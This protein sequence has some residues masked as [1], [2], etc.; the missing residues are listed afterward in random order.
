L[1]ILLFWRLI[2]LLIRRTIRLCLI[3]TILLRLKGLI[4]IILYIWIL[5]WGIYLNLLGLWIRILI[6]LGYSILL[7]LSIGILINLL[8]RLLVYRTRLW[9][10]NWVFIRRLYLIRLTLRYNVLL[11]SRKRILLECYRIRFKLKKRIVVMIL[12]WISNRSRLAF[13]LR[14]WL[15]ILILKRLFCQF[16]ILLLLLLW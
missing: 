5:K 10:R 11:W 7:R 14:F 2:L 9:L 1:I 12:Y 4:L 15:T 6:L 13:R 8:I 3:N 16:L